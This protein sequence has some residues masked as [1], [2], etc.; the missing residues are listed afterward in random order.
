[1]QWN[2]QDGTPN[3]ELGDNNFLNE[4]ASS[5]FVHIE[6]GQAQK[7]SCRKLKIT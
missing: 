3:D 2:L 1:V 6:L 4:K 5:N 7:N